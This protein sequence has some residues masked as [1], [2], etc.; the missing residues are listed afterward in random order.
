MTARPGAVVVCEGCGQPIAA[1]TLPSDPWA[2]SNTRVTDG[3]EPLP[4]PAAGLGFLAE[5][6]RPGPR[7]AGHRRRRCWPTVAARCCPCATTN[8][9]RPESGAPAGA[10]S[11]PASAGHAG[12]G[13]D[14]PD[15]AAARIVRRA[16]HR[17]IAATTAPAAARQRRVNPVSFTTVAGCQLRLRSSDVP[18][19]ATHDNGVRGSV[20][21]R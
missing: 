6:R 5:R 8:R 18:S 17:Q 12:D 3:A 16:S 14:R 15:A 11:R 9:V 10:P 4:L 20:P 21:T 2:C 1:W 7:G 19:A 13:C